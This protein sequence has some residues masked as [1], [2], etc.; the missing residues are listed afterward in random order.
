MPSV[1][2]VR[3]VTPKLSSIFH[4]ISR[5]FRSKNLIFQKFWNILF[6]FNFFSII[7]AR[8]CG[9]NENIWEQS[10][11]SICNLLTN[12][13]W[14]QWNSSERRW[15]IVKSFRK[16][17]WFQNFTKKC[18]ASMYTVYLYEHHQ[19]ITSMLFFRS[20]LMTVIIWW[21]STGLERTVRW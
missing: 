9:K 15:N 16:M 4:T 8:N 14:G 21:W 13:I 17:L 5:K 1:I 11:Q 19:I 7:L 12:I 18:K 10:Y 6:Y 20:I 2:P 3:V